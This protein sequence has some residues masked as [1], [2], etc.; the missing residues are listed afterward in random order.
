MVADCGVAVA[1]EE[2]RTLLVDHFSGIVLALT[3]AASKKVVAAVEAV[4]SSPP[5]MLVDQLSAV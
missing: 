1:E 5:H 2:V 3:L 4:R